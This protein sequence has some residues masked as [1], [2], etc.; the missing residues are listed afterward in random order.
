MSVKG[1]E[2]AIKYSNRIVNE[3]V[4]TGDNAQTSW[5]LDYEA[6]DELGVMTN[7][8]TKIEVFL[9]GILKTPT[10][11]YSLM[12]DGGAAGVGQINFVAAPGQD[13]I[14]TAN[15][16]T[17]AVIGHVQSVGITHSNNVEPVHQIGSQL[18]VDL[19]EGNIDISLSLGRC[20]IGL[21]LVS[22]VIHEISEARGFL[23]ANE[24]D[25][26]VFPKGTTGGNPLLTVRGKFKGY[27]LDMSQDAILMDTADLIGKTIDVT[28]V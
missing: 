3:A 12:G 9:D 1:W 22:I 4:G 18:A 24:F 16:Y 20:F 25:I 23:N 7:A 19:K 28:T 2:G 6:D 15:Y 17:Y 27:S 10:T 5:D 13:V 11:D 26:D 8:P 14:I 21:D